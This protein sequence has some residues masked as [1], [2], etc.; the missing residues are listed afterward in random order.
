MIGAGA[1]RTLGILRA[2]MHEP[3][4]L[5]GGIIHLYDL[6]SRRAK[7]MQQMLHKTP[8][9]LRARCDI[10]YEGTLES[11]LEGADVVGVILPAG[12]AEAYA[13]GH[14]PSIKHGFISSDNVSP[15]GAFCAMRIAPVLMDI[16]AK[17]KR[18]CPQ[19]W[20]VNFANPIA[21]LSS[22][23]EHHFGIPTLGVCAGYT[24]HQW[25]I[26][27]LFSKD[28]EATDL[29]VATAGV[30]HLSYILEGTWQGQD[31]FE[32]MTNRGAQEIELELQPWWPDALKP[33][34]QRSVRRLDRL[35][36]ELG[37]LV[38]STEG[39]GMDHLMYEEAVRALREKGVMS[40]DK[41]KSSLRA[42]AAKRT[43][44]D[45]SFEVLLS[46]DLT[47]EFWT[48]HWKKDYRFQ[49]PADDIFARIFTGLAGAREM[50]IVTS[51]PNSGA[52]IGIKDRH[53]VEYTQ[54]IYKNTINHGGP[55]EIPDCV[56]GITAG[57]AAHQTLLG[58][59]LAHKDPK[60]IAHA[61]LSYPIQPY[62]TSLRQLSREL[63]EINDTHLLPAYSSAI[64]Y[65]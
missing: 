39:D 54:T 17:M 43:E 64:Q 47:A 13:L 35:W 36:K 55:Y 30:N 33:I 8:E 56:H 52:I 48:Q 63:I 65:L 23:V 3:G 50:E 42:Q 2:A 32:L 14:A 6:N 29:T 24:N 21:V 10:R 51:R 53:A 26:P 25:D 62:S 37:V 27:R 18:I 5:D 11:A 28:E 61:L 4:V 44:A 15:S 40:A 31:L 20:L 41:V 16:A 57:L 34:I 49:L 38:F 45:H 1:H 19:A 9:Y 59:A 60:E 7:A 22:M 12:S 58:D 46:K